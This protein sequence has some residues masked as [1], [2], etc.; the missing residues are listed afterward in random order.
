MLLIAAT[1]LLRCRRVPALQRKSLRTARLLLRSLPISASHS[2]GHRLFLRVLPAPRTSSDT[3]S[4]QRSQ[5]LH[6]RGAGRDRGNAKVAWQ[7][8]I[9]MCTN[10]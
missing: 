4:G 3:C 5:A 8:S 9:T 1:A 2:R 7:V 6:A 10:L